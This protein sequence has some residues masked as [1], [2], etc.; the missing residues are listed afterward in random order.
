MQPLS[1]NQRPDLLTALMNM[2]LVLRLPREMHLCG[3]SSNVPRLPTILKLRHSP[4]VFLTFGKLQ[5]LAPATKSYIQVSKSAPRPPVFYTFWLRNVLRAKTACTFWTSPF[6]KGS[7]AEVF[8]TFWLGN[9]LRATTACTFSISQLPKVVWRGCVLH[10]LTSTRHNGLQFCISY[11]TTWLRT[12]RFSEPTFQ[13]SGATNHWKNTVFRDFAT[14]SFTCTFFLL[15]LSPLW[16]S[17]FCSSLLWLFPPLLFHLSM[18]SEVW[19]P[20][21]P[22]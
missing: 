17:F 8:C 3:N 2:S 18:L 10:I 19:L 9:A 22:Q 11:L 4:H 6:L 13:P 1:G 15:I 14:F 20:N 21:F 12:R 16:S 5:A 7:E